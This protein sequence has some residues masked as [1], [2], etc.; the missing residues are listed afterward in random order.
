MNRGRIFD[1]DAS[2]LDIRE[3]VAAL[4]AYV[5]GVSEKQFLANP[6]KQDAVMRRIEMLGEAANRIMRADPDFARSFSTLPLQ[7]LYAMRNR[8]SHGYDSIDLATVWKTATRD[9]VELREQVDRL[10][11]RRPRR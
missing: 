9:A 3:S 2:L 11:A 4:E 5:A 8:I 6:E 7:A 1:I 10:I